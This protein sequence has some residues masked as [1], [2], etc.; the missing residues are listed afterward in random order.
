MN[1][2]MGIANERLYALNIHCLPGNILF[3]Q[4]RS[5]SLYKH[6]LVT[7]IVLDY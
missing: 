4:L 2:D 3:G 6:S 5:H 7:F 1:Q